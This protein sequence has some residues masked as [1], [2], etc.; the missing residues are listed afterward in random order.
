MKPSR[1]GGKNRM[2]ILSVDTRIEHP[3]KMSANNVD[4]NNLVG[5]NQGVDPHAGCRSQCIRGHDNNVCPGTV[6][7]PLR[8][9]TACHHDMCA[10]EQCECRTT[11][12]TPCGGQCACAS[13]VN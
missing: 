5:G 9:E 3:A 8:T 7:R 11:C 1:S 2:F 12:G 4:F 13:K 6:L 10:G